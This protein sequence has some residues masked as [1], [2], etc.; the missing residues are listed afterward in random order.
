M[1]NDKNDDAGR[2]A[3]QRKDL[4]EFVTEP[5]TNGTNGTN[6]VSIVPRQDVSAACG[7]VCATLRRRRR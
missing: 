6:A 3:D 7:G 2:T 4:K 1:V 5:C